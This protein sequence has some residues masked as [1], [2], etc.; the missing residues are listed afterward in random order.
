MG[1]KRKWDDC[2]DYMVCREREM[3]CCLWKFS[4][5][6][7]NR[8][9]RVL[10][11]KKANSLVVSR[12]R[13]WFSSSW[14]RGPIGI[15]ARFPIMQTIWISD[16]CSLLGELPILGNF[17]SVEVGLYFIDINVLLS[18]SCTIIRLLAFWHVRFPQTQEA[19]FQDSKFL[20]VQNYYFNICV[21]INIE[22]QYIMPMSKKKKE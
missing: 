3:R 11:L 13:Q 16:A 20:G 21:Y 19:D 1:G 14:T 4:G 18:Q 12:N 10:V 9:R 7:Q 5:Q 17:D 22:P 2:D 6:K 8:N 15:Q